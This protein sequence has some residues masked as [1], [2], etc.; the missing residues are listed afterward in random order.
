MLHRASAGEYHRSGGSTAWH[1]ES[2]LRDCA[3]A[4]ALLRRDAPALRVCRLL[5]ERGGKAENGV[6]G[7][8]AGTAVPG[9]HAAVLR[10][11]GRRHGGGTAGAAGEA[12]REV[13]YPLCLESFPGSRA[14]C[15]GTFAAGYQER[16]CGYAA[17]CPAYRIRG[18]SEK[19]AGAACGR[20]GLVLCGLCDE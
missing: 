2:E 13:R 17:L 4:A 16:A 10:K 20:C 8:P 11:P 19:D 15:K 14:E 6:S 9:L 12:E 18:I 1:A 7:M 3:A 5:L